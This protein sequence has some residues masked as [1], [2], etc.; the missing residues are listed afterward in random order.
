LLS[1]VNANDTFFEL[2]LNVRRHIMSKDVYIQSLERRLNV[3]DE[4]DDDDD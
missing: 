1:V 2:M 4:T 3:V